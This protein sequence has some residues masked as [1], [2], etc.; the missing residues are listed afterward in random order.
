[1]FKDIEDLLFIGVIALLTA[2]YKFVNWTQFI[3]DGILG[4]VIGI[5]SVMILSY[6]EL[7]KYV[8]GGLGG[9]FVLWSKPFYEA[10]CNLIIVKLPE[11]IDKKLK[12]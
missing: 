3:K 1:M 10:M 8:E 12:D 11:I 9:A 7:P 5:I 2:I 6:F 4:F